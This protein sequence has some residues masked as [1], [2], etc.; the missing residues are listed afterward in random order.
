MKRLD[1]LSAGVVSL[2]LLIPALAALSV[3][4][5]EFELI[6]SDAKKPL[7]FSSKPNELAVKPDVRSFSFAVDGAAAG[8]VRTTTAS[9]S[10]AASSTATASPPA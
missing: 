10:G 1:L 4:G 7:V 8:R 3:R 5:E 9:S 2:S 6:P